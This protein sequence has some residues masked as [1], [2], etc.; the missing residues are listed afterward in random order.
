VSGGLPHRVGTPANVPGSLRRTASGLA[1]DRRLTGVASYVFCRVCDDRHDTYVRARDDMTGLVEAERYYTR[2]AR[3]PKI[4]R[5]TP[6]V[7]IGSH[8]GRGLFLLGVCAGLKWERLDASS[9]PYR[10]RIEVIWDGAI[11]AADYATVFESVAKYNERSWTSATLADY[12]LV[13]DRILAGDVVR[14]VRDA[15]RLP[16]DE[17]Q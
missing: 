11:Y 12:R 2:N 4:M 14:R 5:R 17:T 9:L 6:M 1:P 10:H 3:P 15:P 7:G 16:W 8:G 13:V